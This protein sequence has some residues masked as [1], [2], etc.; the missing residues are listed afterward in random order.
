M[1]KLS[2]LWTVIDHATRE[3]VLPM[4]CNPNAP[5]GDEGFLVYRSQASAETAAEHQS[6][7]YSLDCAACRLDRANLEVVAGPDL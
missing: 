3:P 4:D 7:M 6:K 2:D 5:D 1:T